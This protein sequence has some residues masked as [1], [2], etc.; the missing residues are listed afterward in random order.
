MPKSRHRK[1]HK[2]KVNARSQK[3][4]DDKNKLLKAQKEFLMRMIEEEQKKGQFDNLPGMDDPI[5]DGPSFG[6]TI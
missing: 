1:N 4:K 6:P 5:I 2:K 3:I